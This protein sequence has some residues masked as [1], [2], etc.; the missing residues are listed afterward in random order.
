SAPNCSSNPRD[1]A[2]RP[3]GDP[4]I[5][6]ILFGCRRIEFGLHGDAT[7]QRRS[8]GIGYRRESVAAIHAAM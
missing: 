4:A 7:T 1:P 5:A 6:A 3:S 2:V 8:P